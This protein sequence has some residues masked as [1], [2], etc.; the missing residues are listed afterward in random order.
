VVRSQRK[1]ADEKEKSDRSDY[2]DTP[3]RVN[4][5]AELLGA[6]RATELRHLRKTNELS[7]FIAVANFIREQPHCFALQ[8]LHNSAQCSSVMTL[9]SPP[10]RAAG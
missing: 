9:G 2:L 8:T 5:D 7:R 3:Y 10:R 6:N 1:I 4:C